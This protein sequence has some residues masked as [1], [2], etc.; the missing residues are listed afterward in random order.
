MISSLR[1]AD[2]TTQMMGSEKMPLGFYL[3]KPGSPMA[4]PPRPPRPF[5]RG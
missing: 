1:S 5:L 3:M 2:W 4:R